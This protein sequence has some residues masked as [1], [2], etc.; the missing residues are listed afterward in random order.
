MT[1]RA[2]GGSEADLEKRIAAE[3]TRRLPDGKPDKPQLPAVDVPKKMELT[4]V[5]KPQAIASAISLGF[6]LT[7]N[8]GDDDYYV[9][10]LRKFITQGVGVRRVA[11]GRL[12]GIGRQS[13]PPS[14]PSTPF[15]DTS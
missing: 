4:I 8:R 7:I 14:P 13:R 6:P 5:Q 10:K 3:L 12:V 2:T 11:P 1:V 9:D 15:R